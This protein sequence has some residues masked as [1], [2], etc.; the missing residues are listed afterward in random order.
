MNTLRVGWLLLALLGSACHHF[1]RQPVTR[2]ADSGHTVVLSHGRVCEN[3][4]D[5]IIATFSPEL[6]GATWSLVDEA[7]ETVGTGPVSA[8]FPIDTK[9]L[10]PNRYRVM[11]AL[12]QSETEPRPPLEIHFE[13]FHCVAD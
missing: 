7:D 6:P 5:P 9:T 8:T 12:A 13:V 4:A 11:I 1:P 10:K 2:K 3:E